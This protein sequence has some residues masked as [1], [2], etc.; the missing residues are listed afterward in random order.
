MRRVVI[1]TGDKQAGPL[2]QWTGDVGY[3][4]IVDK[5]KFV[6]GVYPIPIGVIVPFFLFLIV[7]RVPRPVEKDKFMRFSIFFGKKDLA[8]MRV[9]WFKFLNGLG[10]SVLPNPGI[11]AAVVLGIFLPKLREKIADCKKIDDKKT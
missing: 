3:F 8:V 6:K 5:L 4:P 2:G 7:G 11:L 9:E 1:R 10:V